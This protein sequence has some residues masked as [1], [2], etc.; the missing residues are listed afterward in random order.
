VYVR[1]LQFISVSS[2]IPADKAPQSIV[3]IYKGI[4][5]D[6]KYANII[7]KEIYK[8][9]ILTVDELSALLST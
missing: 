4:R 6:C 7:L 9:A 8:D 3:L 5:V 2:H 1:G